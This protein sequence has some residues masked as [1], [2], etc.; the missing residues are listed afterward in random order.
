MKSLS[1]IYSLDILRGLMAILI[2][3]YHYTSWSLG[4]FWGQRFV[5]VC[6]IYGVAIFYILSGLT[7]YLV[8]ESSLDLRSLSRYALKRV[9]RIYPLLILSIL[10]TVF[11]LDREHGWDAILLNVSGLFGF[12][13]PDNYIAIG[14]WS[15][16]NELVY[17]ALFPVVLIGA[18]Y[19]P[20]WI[21][22][23][24]VVALGFAG[25]YAVDVLDAG[26]G[27]HGQWYRYVEPFNHWFL[28]VG[29]MLIGKYGVK[30]KASWIA[31][32]LLMASV[33]FFVLYPVASRIELA[34]GWGRL[35]YSLASFM[36]VLAVYRIPDLHSDKLK[37]VSLWLGRWSYSIYLL[38][39][40]VFFA[41][42]YLVNRR[43]YPEWYLLVSMVITLVV[44]GLVYCYF[45]R[46]FQLLGK[47]KGPI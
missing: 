46:P 21:E 14:S 20:F 47:G 6:G 10:L 12:V 40:I 8:Y 33:L 44:S 17:Y 43:A 27:L 26:E 7:L 34:T 45:E 38:H 19:I 15:I 16:G 13:D 42:A 37:S 4:G 11:M 3:V 36:M 30:L 41:G 1:R 2:M 22:I 23:M 32:G 18:R 39:P 24:F 28:F 25:W 9:L 29:G 5:A 35:M 31:W